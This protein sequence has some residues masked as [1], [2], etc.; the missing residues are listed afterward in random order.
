MLT[1]WLAVT[2]KGQSKPIFHLPFVCKKIPVKH[3]LPK[4]SGSGIERGIVAL[5]GW[6]FCRPPFHT[7]DL[8]V[9]V[10][11]AYSSEAVS[12]LHYKG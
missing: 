7:F 6:F 2:C 10:R 4:A 3:F 5:F 9:F 11:Q 8:H 12:L 1:F